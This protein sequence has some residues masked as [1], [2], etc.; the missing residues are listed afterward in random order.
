M[1][2]RLHLSP[3]VV[4]LV[5][6]LLSVA[7]VVA[8]LVSYAWF[9]SRRGLYTLTQ[10][11]EPYTL[12]IKGGNQT[13]IEQ[14][15]LSQ[16]DLSNTTYQ[17]NFV[18]CITGSNTTPYVLEL[19][20]TTNIPFT[21]TLY[22][23]TQL[24]SRPSDDTVVVYNDPDSKKSFYYSKI[25]ANK[26]A[27]TPIN[28]GSGGV[29]DSTQHDSTYGTAIPS[30][31]VQNNAEPLYLLSNSITPGSIGSDA[32]TYADY[33]ILELTWSSTDATA[34]PKETDLVYLMAENV[35]H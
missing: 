5:A 30:A 34:Y 25:T 21:Y 12:A 15:D 10:V 19:A 6:A 28:A 2:K 8:A 16:I 31:N 14:L 4:R 11:S 7:L 17:A 13:E 32:K 27:T 20:H 3:S 1:N 24:D 33:Y 23:T 26:L 9:Y 29:A 35:S 22:K 18:F